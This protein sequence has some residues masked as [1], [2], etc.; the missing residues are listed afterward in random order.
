MLW[1]PWG[2]DPHRG[3]RPLNRQQERDWTDGQFY[4]GGET[5]RAGLSNK[6]SIF[7]AFG[8]FS[9]NVK[10]GIIMESM[11]GCKTDAGS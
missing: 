10:P 9:K 6:S 3:A 4:S 7:L 1:W 11:T 5:A 2:E 8:E